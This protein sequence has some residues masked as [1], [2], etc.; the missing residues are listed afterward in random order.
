MSLSLIGCNEKKD[1]NIPISKLKDG[2]IVFRRGVGI[3]SQIVLRV[4]TKSSYSHTGIIKF[5]D[6][7]CCVIHAVPE[8]P[9]FK[10][11]VDR[12]KLEHI[13]SF[14]SWEKASSGAIMRIENITDVADKAAENAYSLYMR[15]IL[16]DHDYDIKDSTEM[17]CTELV[18]YVYRKEGIDLPEKRLNKINIPG[19]NGEYL[20]PSGIA[21]NKKLHVIYKY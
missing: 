9:D 4:D 20:F 3:T 14:F 16:F 2:D 1:L 21:D 13:N 19:F 8:E 12:V 17:Y 7:K 6:G 5:V 10:G 11:D 18:D 15:K